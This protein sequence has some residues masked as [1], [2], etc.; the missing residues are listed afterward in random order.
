MLVQNPPE[1]L[2]PAAFTTRAA[3][4]GRVS[5]LVLLAGL[6]GCFG[7]SSASLEEPEVAAPNGPGSPPPASAEDWQSLPQ[8]SRL[9]VSAV[10]RLTRAE[11]E[12]S[13]EALFGRSFPAAT[14]RL[15]EDFL[16]VEN[17]FDNDRERQAQQGAG[18][19]EQMEALAREVAQELLGTVGYRERFTGVQGVATPG[20]TPSG[21]ALSVWNRLDFTFQAPSAGSHRLTVRAFGEQAPP[22]PARFLLSVDGVDRR[23][24]DVPA[25]RA[26]AGTY[27]LELALG[28]GAHTVSVTFLNDFYDG[29]VDRNLFVESVELAASAGVSPVADWAGCEPTSPD[30]AACLRRLA[31][32]LGRRILRRPLSPAELDSLA[33]LNALGTLGGRFEDAAAGVLRSLLTHPEFIHR[34]EIGEPRAA[35]PEVIELSPLSL[36]SKMSFALTGATPPE[37][38]LALAE[39]GGLD[40]ADQR[41]VIARRLLASPRGQQQVRKFHAQWLGYSGLGEGARPFI[42]ESNALVDATTFGPIADHRALF[43]WPKTFVSA[44]VAEHYG[45][46]APAE[47]EGDWVSYPD[48]QRAGILSHATF[49][50]LQPSGGDTSPTHRGRWVMLRL[51]CRPM[52]E[53]PGNVPITPAP[54]G[55][56]KEDYITNLHATEG[57]QSCHAEMDPIGFGLEGFGLDG[58]ARELEPEKPQC[59][60]SGEGSVPRLAAFNGPGELGRLLA[61]SPEVD[62]CVV[63]HV[64]R[65]AEGRE[66]EVLAFDAAAL[67]RWTEGYRQSGYRFNEL[68]IAIVSDDHF[69]LRREPQ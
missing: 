38:L 24:F 9:T 60:I 64:F 59:R 50:T 7:A 40:T 45:L 10:R 19:A 3:V 12:A 5:I 49:L 11:V 65:F 29:T 26:A 22:E 2:R 43:T 32:N 42:D 15:P 27:A 36:A 28:A 23:T 46:P 51:L 68:L 61:Q 58:K 47:P 21:T 31:A 54:E 18:L 16:G 34:F 39:A 25:T 4:G 53:A 14:A 63:R 41:A 13:L 62:A 69:R 6:S 67:Q 56:C 37:W 1:P 55:V 17:P 20:G 52:G 48:A 66:E 57:C 8:P 30:D 33:A 35:A 44:P